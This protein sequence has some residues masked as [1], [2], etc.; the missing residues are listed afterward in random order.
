M[1]TLT[2]SERRVLGNSLLFADVKPASIDAALDQCKVRELQP[3]EVLVS[4]AHINRFIYVVLSGRFEVHI[5]ETEQSPLASISAGECIGEM[6]VLD[7]QK[8]SARVIAAVPSRVIELHQDLIWQF[9]DATEGMARNLLYILS[10]R[11]RVNT[12]ALFESLRRQLQFERYADLDGLTGLYNRRWL[13]RA[14]EQYLVT[15]ENR[16]DAPP[17]TI[18]LLDVDHFKRF[19]DQHGHPAGDI[20]LRQVADT[21]SQGLRPDDNAARYGGEEFAVLLADADVQVGVQ[22]AERLCDAVRE[23]RLRDHSGNS[24]P[25][26]TISLGVAQHRSGQSMVQWLEAAD[27]ALYCAKET[28]RDRVSAA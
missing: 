26:V 27:S 8:P 24:L 3:Q 2:D 1:L 23:A 11:L 6:S 15:A 5:G 20:A 17:M 13:D 10:S 21:V 18:I 16:Q 12:E 22:I 7:S 25:S 9:I 19:N 14:M 4:P 28:G